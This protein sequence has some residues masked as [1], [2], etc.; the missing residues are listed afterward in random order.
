MIGAGM[1]AGLDAVRLID[2]QTYETLHRHELEA[3]ERGTAL[4]SVSF[5]DDPEVYYVLGTAYE[6][7]NE[8]EPT[9]VRPRRMQ[10]CAL[11]SMCMCI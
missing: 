11:I 7:P 1:D 3:D 4:A 5:A 6:L 10:A 2:D 8:P 9:R